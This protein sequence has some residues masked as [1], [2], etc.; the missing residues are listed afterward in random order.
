MGNRHNAA[1]LLSSLQKSSL[2]G[3]DVEKDLGTLWK[4]YDQDSSGWLEKGEAHKF[5][6]EVYDWLSSSG[7]VW[8]LFLN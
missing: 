3:K 6:A 7:T 4:K 5:F 2:A 1:S 8:V